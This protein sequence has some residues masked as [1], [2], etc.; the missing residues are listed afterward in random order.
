MTWISTAET[1]F[2][3][4]TI[5]TS[6][7]TYP[8]ALPARAIQQG[9]ASRMSSSSAINAMIQGDNEYYTS[10]VGK[11]LRDGSSHHASMGGV[12]GG[13]QPHEWTHVQ[14]NL[15]HHQQHKGGEASRRV[16]GCTCQGCNRANHTR[17][18][19]RLRFNED[20]NREGPWAVLV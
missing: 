8:D 19:C 4:S 14:R 15:I 18:F 20:F 17:E 9:L 16:Q 5:M 11:T 10:D 6:S 2:P 12:D 13:E 7:R 1:P 3:T